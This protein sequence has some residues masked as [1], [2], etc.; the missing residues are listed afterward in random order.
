[1]NTTIHIN[2]ITFTLILEK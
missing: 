2:Q 1:M